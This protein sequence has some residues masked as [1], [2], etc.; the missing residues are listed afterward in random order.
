MSVPKGQWEAGRTIGLTTPRI[1]LDVVFV[2]AMRV[3]GPPFIN[4]CIMVVK[5]TSLNPS[6]ARRD[7]T[8]VG[9]QIVERTLAPFDIFG[10]VALVYFVICF[11]LS[12]PGR[13]FESRLNYVP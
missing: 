13:Y 5:G 10:A 1:L 7:V 2:Q 8:Y 3:A 6:S 12:Y 11:A 4:T 9:K